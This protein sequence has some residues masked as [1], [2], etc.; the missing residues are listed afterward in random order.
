VT[1]I[2][3]TDQATR[4]ILAL[5]QEVH[6]L[7][8][9]GWPEAMYRDAL[10]IL[11][12]EHLIPCRPAA[13]VRGAGPVRAAIVC[14]DSILVRVCRESVAEPGLRRSLAASGLER[15]VLLRFE[16]Q[17]VVSRIVTV[18]AP[19]HLVMADPSWPAFSE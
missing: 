1:E 17:D 9:G 13:G 8:G 3:T 2:H 19:V 12:E 18:D 11:C 4:Q 14:C 10:L 6:R 5:A 16:D 15:A 7:L